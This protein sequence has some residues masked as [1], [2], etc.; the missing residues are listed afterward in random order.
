[1]LLG[2][3]F[4][5]K[6]MIPNA[7]VIIILGG[8]HLSTDVAKSWNQTNFARKGQEPFVKKMATKE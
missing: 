3:V 6:R 4:G 8:V 7:R 1:M 2:T 5:S